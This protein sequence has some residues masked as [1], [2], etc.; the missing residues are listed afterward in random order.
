MKT[1]ILNIDDVGM[2]NSF[3]DAALSILRLGLIE[4]ISVMAVGPWVCEFLEALRFEN[5]EPDI[6]IHLCLTSE[7]P[8]CK[9]RPL[10]GETV[11]SLLDKDGFLHESVEVLAKKADFMEVQLELRA[12]VFYLKRLGVQISHIDSHMLFYE[13]SPALLDAVFELAEEIDIPLLMYNDN[14]IEMAK[15]RGL[16][17]PDFGTLNNYSFVLFERLK[18]Y[19]K[20]IKTFPNKG[21]GALALHPSFI[22][23]EALNCMG[24]IETKCRYEELQIFSQLLLPIELK[25]LRP[26]DVWRNRKS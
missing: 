18:E 14:Y 20:L 22:T 17:C 11:P 1:V 24:E 8:N 3:N 12:Q 19:H 23:D 7:W 2:L 10:L 5:L 4:S 21:V 15:V 9:I 13:G 25:V 6:G 26:R 16:K